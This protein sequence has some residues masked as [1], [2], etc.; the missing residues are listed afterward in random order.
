[1]NEMLY[2][3]LEL[4]Y[5]HVC[6]KITFDRI[7]GH[8]TS[9]WNFI[10]ELF[11]KMAACGHFG[12][13]KFTFDRISGHFR[14]IRNC[15]LRRPFW[16]FENY[17]R[18][19]FWPFWMFEDHFGLHFCTFQINME[20]FIF[21]IFLTKWPPAATL[22]VRKSLSIAFLDISDRCRTYY[23]FWNFWQ[24]GRRRPVWMERQCQLSNSSKIFGWVMHVS[25]LNNVV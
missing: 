12:C 6:P 18:S 10:F 21:F 8:F 24:N 1:M 13:P 23:I 20:L 3:I 11:D 14:S 2:G 19:H 5:H 4:Y 17:F 25:C 15:F 9:I 7:S 22:D 16:M